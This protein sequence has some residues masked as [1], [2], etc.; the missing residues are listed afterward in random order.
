MSNATPD[1]VYQQLLGWFCIT[2]I[3]PDHTILE[4]LGL[5]YGIST[6]Y[7]LFN[8]GILFISECFIVFR[9]ISSMFIV[10]CL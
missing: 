10:L 1:W 6:L 3:L 9:T 5:F 4:H 8:T 2:M 7:G